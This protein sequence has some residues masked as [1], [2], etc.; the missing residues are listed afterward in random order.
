MNKRNQVI[1]GVIWKFGERMLAQ[2][3]SFA[4]S[5]VLARLLSP[6]DYG[7]I[8]MVL[9]F[10]SIADVFVSSGFTAALIQRKDADD[11][12]FSTIFYCS[13]L[14]SLLIY[15]LLF[16]A[17]PLIANFYNNPS[18][19][20]II[21][22]F[23][24][25]IPLSVY[26]SIQHAYVSRHMLFKKLFLSTLLGTALSG[27]IG[28]SMAY[29]G[30]GV[31]AL[32]GQYFSNT[33]INTIVLQFTVRWRPR[34]LFSLDRARLLMSFGSRILLADL[35]GT[36]FGQLRSLI[37]G[38]FFTSADLAY[39]NKGQQLPSLFTDNIS[40]SVMAVL[41][42]VMSNESGEVERVKQ[43]TAQSLRMVSYLMFPLLF[44]LAA[45]AQPFVLLLYTDKW[46]ACIPFVQMLCASAAIGLL[47]STA[48]QALKAMGQ[49]DTLVRLEF[50]K[51]PVYVLL[52][53]LGVRISVTAVAVT[54]VLYD[55]YGT[56]VNMSRLKGLLQY[57]IREQ[58]CDVAPAAVFSA[59]MVA[60]L[61]LLQ[62]ENLWLCLFV[63]VA[64]G[65]AIYGLLSVLTCNQSFLYLKRYL[66]SKLR[67]RHAK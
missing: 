56:L 24:L 10:I 53:V 31:W 32:I 25:R 44:G 14:A 8:A 1:S 17:S 48:L 38:K 50:V 59:V 39:Y 11:T 23:S 63:K 18:L 29:C 65:M 20:T 42:P 15:G 37:I 46:A 5:V 3:V 45:V 34:K 30:L 66:I 22:V 7:V 52:L 40:R 28:I 55:I 61:S 27:V 35:S 36:F 57:S 54:M 4:V 26:N 43:M 21:R 6:D 9:V 58:L 64:C 49:G 47:G 60:L 62:I 41:F 67:H 19:T 2:L 16:L 51:K 13:G 33:I 12:D